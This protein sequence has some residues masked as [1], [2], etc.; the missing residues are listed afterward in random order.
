MVLIIGIATACSPGSS[1]GQNNGDDDSL[2][3]CTFSNPV[4]KGQDP[5]ITKKGNYYYYIESRGGG[6]YV[7]KSKELTN[8]K[9]NEKLVWSLPETGWNQHSLWAPEL[10][11]VNGQWYIYYT[12]GEKP[13]SPFISQRSGV[14]QAKTA[15][16]MGGYIDK[17]QLYTGNDIE[18]KADNIWSIDLTVLEHEDQLYGIWSGWE[19]NRDTDQTPQHLYIAEMENSWTISSNRVKISSPEEEWEISSSLPINE[20]AQILKHNGDV[21]IVYSASQSWLPSYKLGQLKLVGEDPMNP[22]HWQKSGPVFEGSDLVHGI[23]HAS[24]TTSPDGKEHWI[25]YHTK[26][27]TDPGWNRVIHMQPFGWQEDGSPQFD[28]PVVAGKSLEKPSGTCS[29]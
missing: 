7:S 15:D 25:A 8:I 24:F 12:A 21:F 18:T 27:S 1:A 29:E 14:L 10:H 16:P 4:A 26:V 2:I 9:Q 23:G 17:G 19:E 20:G 3:P 5:W 28:R 22:E 11:F 13:G 6:L